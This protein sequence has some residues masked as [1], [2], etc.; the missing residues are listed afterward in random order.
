MAYS[1]VRLNHAVQFV[2]RLERSLRF[3][4]DSF[5]MEVIAVEPRAKAAFLALRRSGHHHDLGLFGVA[6]DGSRRRRGATGLSHLAWQV[7]AIEQW[8]RA[9]RT[10]LQAAVH[11]GASSRGP[12][13][14]RRHRPRWQRVRDRV[15]AATKQLEAAQARRAH[16]EP[17]PGR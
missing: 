13:E 11:A 17:R 5:E 9:R 10:L 3:Y 8:A 1:P 4:A 15:D 16:R 7:D 12:V 6:D 14:R 2:A